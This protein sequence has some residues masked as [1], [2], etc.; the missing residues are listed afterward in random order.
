[1]ARFA[2]TFEIRSHAELTRARTTMQLFDAA[3][4]QLPER[5]AEF[6]EALAPILEIPRMS[7]FANA[8]V[9]RRAV[10][11]M[12]PGAAYV[13]VGVW[14]GFSLFAGMIGN[15]DRRVVGIDDFSQFGGPRDEMTARFRGFASANHAFHDMDYA[16]YFETAHQGPIGLYFYDGEHSYANQLRGLEVAEPFFA[17]DCLV[18]VDDTNL[19]EPRQATADFMA[20]SKHRYAVLMDRRT[21][22]N[23]HPTFWNG[24]ML[25]RRVG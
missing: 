11:E 15:T 3:I 22:W 12:A 23:G 19:P 25:L 4:T 2:P 17:A 8:A 7:T 16:R 6:L 10:E 5:H 1:M 21:A 9:I 24:L 13:N 18:L 14:H 20:R